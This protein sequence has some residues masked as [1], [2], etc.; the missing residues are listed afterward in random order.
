MKKLFITLLLLPIILLIGSCNNLYN[1]IETMDVNATVPITDFIRFGSHNSNGVDDFIHWIET[2]EEPLWNHVSDFGPLLDFIRQNGSILT[3]EEISGEFEFS[4]I[5][6]HPHGR[7]SYIFMANID[8]RNFITHNIILYLTEFDESNLS[9]TERVTETAEQHHQEIFQTVQIDGIQY[10]SAVENSR[11]EIVSLESRI[12]E[13]VNLYSFVSSSRPIVFFEIDGVHIRINFNTTNRRDLIDSLN[14]GRGW[15]SSYLDMFQF[16]SRPINA[17]GRLPDNGGIGEF[18][19]LPPIG[20]ISV[21]LDG[22]PIQ[23]LDAEPII[24][25]DRTL[26]PFRAIFEALDMD[27]EWDD[28]R[29]VAIGTRDNLTI[30]IPIDSAIA[31]VNGQIV[32]LDVPAMIHNDRTLV[33]LRFIAEATGAEVDWNDETR[34]VVI[35]R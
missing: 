16:V 5:D 35:A 14:E 30:E 22:T 23:F 13:Q 12:L 19:I 26:V 15:D 3:V 21:T 34:T 27:V 7:I 2:G 32:E 18:P 29:R 11:G 8:G 6:V 9:L 10:V 24:V 25:E 17:G 31:T 1:I 33:P 20:E 4:S 28:D